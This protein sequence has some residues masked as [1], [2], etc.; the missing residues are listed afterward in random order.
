MV[1]GC[2]GPLDDRKVATSHGSLP[3]VHRSFSRLDRLMAVLWDERVVARS[4]TP[5]SLCTM[6]QAAATFTSKSVKIRQ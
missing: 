6:P 4:A 5:L 3:S 2:R 1:A